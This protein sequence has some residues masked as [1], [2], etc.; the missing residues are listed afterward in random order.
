MIGIDFVS[1]PDYTVCGAAYD[2]LVTVLVISATVTLMALV[3]GIVLGSREEGQE[4]GFFRRKPLILPSFAFV[5]TMILVI[6]L[7]PIPMAQYHGL[8][9]VQMHFNASD[10]ANF[11]TYDGIAY[12]SAIVIHALTYLES[13]ESVV[14]QVEIKQE[15]TVIAT[16]TIDLNGTS[17]GSMT[18]EEI[19][20]QL[21][22]GQYEIEISYL[23][24]NYGTPVSDSKWISVVLSQP[25][26]SGFFD[27]VLEW[28]MYMFFIIAGSFFFILIGLCAAREDKK[29][30]S[31]EKIDQEP[32]R[33]G[34]IYARHF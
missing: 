7:Y 23:Q 4:P 28:E 13:G 25:L 14:V 20:V 18:D 10:T 31:Q 15:S 1:R 9:E 26:A 32:P 22:P 6:G 5:I 34:E 3:L 17:L 33:D 30:F 21:Q 16:A 12:Q 8:N 27:E 2:S 29:R 24:F 11:S 19:Q